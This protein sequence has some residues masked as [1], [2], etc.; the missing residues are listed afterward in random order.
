M[1][2]DF[3]SFVIS[4][5]STLTASIGETLYG[6]FLTVDAAGGADV[7]DAGQ[8]RTD[9]FTVSNSE[10][11]ILCGTNTGDHLYFD[12]T[13]ECHSLDFQFGNV[14][15]GVTS[16]AN[17]AWNIKITQYSCDFPNLAPSGCT[18]YFYGTEATNHVRT[19]N[20]SS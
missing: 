20:W 1:R 9:T 11:P 5:P 3:N 7:T 16:L 6:N 13:T 10:V 8:C 2:L 15:N 12:A 19:F 4:G 17:R 18:Q 14:A